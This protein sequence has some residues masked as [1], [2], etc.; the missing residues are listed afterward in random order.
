MTDKEEARQKAAGLRADLLQTLNDIHYQRS[1]GQILTNTYQKALDD[2]SS[3]DSHDDLLRAQGAYRQIR[4][5]LLE[6]IGVD[7]VGKVAQDEISRR[8]ESLLNKKESK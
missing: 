8:L 2:L 4:F 7:Q 5:V 6:Q 1:V 3:A